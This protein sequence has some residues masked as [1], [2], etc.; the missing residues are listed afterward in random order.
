MFILRSQKIW[1]VCLTISFSFLLVSCDVV[2]K[3]LQKEGAEEKEILGEILPRE[4][5]LKVLEVQKLLK[6]YGYKVGNPD[7]ILGANTREAILQFQIDNGLKET[8]FVDKATW[9]KLRVFEKYG[10]VV[11]GELNAVAVQTALKAAGIDAGKVDG[12]M[13]TKT[14]NA[15]KTFQKAY[16][17]KP[18]G[19]I[20]IKTLSALSQY[21]EVVER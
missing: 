21:L 18:D 19:K 15:I 20:G 10:L 7:G 1:F 6:L 13:G 3:I 8:R 9:E 5:N 14:L 2:Y 17:L 12:K 4:K 11:E 16:G